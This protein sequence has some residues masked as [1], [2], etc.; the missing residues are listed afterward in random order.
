MLNGTLH[1]LES[2]ARLLSESPDPGQ[3]YILQRL[4]DWAITTG[5]YLK[6]VI[7]ALLSMGLELM[8]FCIVPESGDESDIKLT[9]EFAIVKPG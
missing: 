2:T 1:G 6:D 5:W 9:S 4:G 8:R 7:L 3:K